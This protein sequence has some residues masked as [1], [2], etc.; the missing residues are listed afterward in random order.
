MRETYTQLSAL[1]G[2][3]VVNREL[4]KSERNSTSIESEVYSVP[5]NHFFINGD[6][7]IDSLLHWLPYQLS[8]CIWVLNTHPGDFTSRYLLCS[9]ISSILHYILN[10]L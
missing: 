10:Y 7:I 3:Y 1:E 4:K 8:D 6:E 9:Y 2:W 5:L